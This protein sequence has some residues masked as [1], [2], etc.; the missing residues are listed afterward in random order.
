MRSKPRMTADKNN[1]ILSSAAIDVTD[2]RSVTSHGRCLGWIMRIEFCRSRAS[3]A[4]V[5]KSHVS[6]SD[7]PK[8]HLKAEFRGAFGRSEASSD[9]D[10]H[11]HL[12]FTPPNTDF[13][14]DAP[15]C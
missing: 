13:V 10:G 9:R 3:F 7:E 15:T 1:V 8:P 4:G 6:C 2:W 12:K 5:V 14:V 11:G